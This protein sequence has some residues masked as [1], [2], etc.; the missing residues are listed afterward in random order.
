M[1]SFVIGV[2][3]FFLFFFLSKSIK[4]IDEKTCYEE[5]VDDLDGA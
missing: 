5:F 3:A 1:F 2:I 4:R